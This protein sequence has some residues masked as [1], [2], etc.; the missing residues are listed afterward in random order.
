MTWALTVLILGCLYIVC[1][2]LIE[3]FKHDCGCCQIQ[4]PEPNGDQNEE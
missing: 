2:T 1:T 4:E 3:A